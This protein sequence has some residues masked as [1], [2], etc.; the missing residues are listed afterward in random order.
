[1][2]LHQFI[3]VC[4][5][6]FLI[7]TASISNACETNFIN[8]IDSNYVDVKFIPVEDKNYIVY[9]VGDTDDGQSRRLFHN[10]KFVIL[11]K[12]TCKPMKLIAL[13][14][15]NDAVNSENSQHE[16]LL[17]ENSN[18]II[19]SQYWYIL[20]DKET[21]NTISRYNYSTLEK[22]LEKNLEPGL[23]WKRNRKDFINN[24]KE[25]IVQN[26]QKNGSIVLQ[27]IDVKDLNLLSEYKI[28]VDLT[29]KLGIQNKSGFDVVEISKHDFEKLNLE[30]FY[31]EDTATLLSIFGVDDTGNP[32]AIYYSMDNQ[33]QGALWYEDDKLFHRAVNEYESKFQ[34]II[35]VLTESKKRN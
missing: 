2:F 28:D 14:P 3:L 35:P 6:L 4:I 1:M 22:E 17:S 23:F 31:P 21:H 10:P 8:G 5:S 25:I 33:P 18:T 34:V 27:K 19:V 32:R 29:A 26:K 11:E 9:R 20:K 30:W 7:S 24:G 15:Q 12:S 13:D 16:I